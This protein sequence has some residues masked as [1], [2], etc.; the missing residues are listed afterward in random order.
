MFCSYRPILLQLE[1]VYTSYLFNCFTLVHVE[2]GLKS[3]NPLTAFRRTKPNRY[4]QK[5]KKKKI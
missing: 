4:Q 2:V 1:P 5:K 3:E